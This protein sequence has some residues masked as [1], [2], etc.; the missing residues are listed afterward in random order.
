VGAAAVEQLNL[1]KLRL[2]RQVGYWFQEQAIQ[3][4]EQAV[5]FSLQQELQELRLR[6]LVLQEA[7]SRG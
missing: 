5:Q 2:A 7:E 4:Q 1:W 3:F 6:L